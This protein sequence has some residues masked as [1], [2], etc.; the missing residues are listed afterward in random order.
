M[1]LFEKL[2]DE[3]RML[4]VYFENGISELVSLVL[5]V[6]EWLIYLA[7]HWATFSHP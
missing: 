3:L 6:S 2:L 1:H 5:R 4:S 7:V